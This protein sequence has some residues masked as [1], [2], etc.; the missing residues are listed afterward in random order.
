M[1]PFGFLL[2]HVGVGCRFNIGGVEMRIL[3]IA[4]LLCAYSAAAAAQ[5][6]SEEEAYRLAAAAETMQALG[7]WPDN[8][9][10]D[11]L[12]LIVEAMEQHGYEFPMRSW[13]L[14][15]VV[16]ETR[17]ARDRGRLG[18]LRSDALTVLTVQAG[19]RL[20]CGETAAKAAHLDSMQRAFTETSWLYGGGAGILRVIGA[21]PP[22]MSAVLVGAAVTAMAGTVA[23]WMAT[24]YRNAPCV[25]TGGAPWN[26]P[27]LRKLAEVMPVEWSPSSA[28]SPGW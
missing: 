2:S 5:E 9:T 12:P 22:V 20:S 19:R 21:A 4:V 3:V 24:Q 6:V 13:E 11:S 25:V 14:R 27:L 8:I 15:E 23:G 17:E 7:V 10:E 16:R 26:V 1:S 28:W 18:R